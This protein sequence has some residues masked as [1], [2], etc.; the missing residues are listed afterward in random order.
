MAFETVIV[1]HFHINNH[2]TV[3]F[4]PNSP[5]AFPIWKTAEIYRNSGISYSEEIKG[6]YD[7]AMGDSKITSS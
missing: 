2:C 3:A 7:F 4:A 5:N 1:T 6:V